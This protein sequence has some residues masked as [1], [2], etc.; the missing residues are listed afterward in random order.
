MCI[1]V[2][3]SWEQK[4][5]YKQLTQLVEYCNSASIQAREKIEQI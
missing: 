2:A 4:G 3:V 5:E 1:Y